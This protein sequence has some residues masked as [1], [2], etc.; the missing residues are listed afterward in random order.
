MTVLKAIEF[1][2]GRTGVLTPV[3]RLEPVRI[4]GVTVTNA[5]LHNVALVERLDLHVGDTVI[6]RRAGDVIPQVMGVVDARRPENPEPFR[7]PESCPECGSQVLRSEGELVARCS[8]GLYCPAQRKQA[9]LHF[10]ARRAMD[11]DGLGDKLVDQLVECGLVHSPADLYALET[12]QLAELERMGERSAT[13]LAA[14]ISKS[15]E[16][17]L[18][19]FLYALGIPEVGEATAQPLAA[20]F[21]D[22][23]AVRQADEERL[24][25]VPDVG[26]IV[27]AHIAGFFREPHNLEIV[28]RLLARGVRW[29]ATAPAERGTALDG[30]TFVLTG[31]LSAMTRDEAK[32][33]LQALGARVA[34]SVSRKTDFVVA[35][36]E[37][38]SK[39]EKARELGVEVLDEAGPLRLSSEGG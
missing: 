39:L 37:A 33:R 36:E 38:G 5:T 11:I 34:G 19:R 22:L 4:G 9:I 20:E 16:T 23:E 25:Q 24:Q 1:Q 12:A 17:T 6:V 30:K 26:P 27:A 15:R 21:G 8:G 14:A 29:P 28:A 3:A 10:A 2:V 32:A 7:V 31:T 35:G 18:A 13:K